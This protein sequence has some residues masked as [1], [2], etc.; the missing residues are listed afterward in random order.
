MLL[1]VFT[2][3]HGYSYWN[4]ENYLLL[5]LT[6]IHWKLDLN[7]CCSTWREN[8]KNFTSKISYE[9]ILETFLSL[10]NKSKEF[11]LSMVTYLLP[12]CQRRK[13]SE[14]RET[15][16]FS[17]SPSLIRFSVALQ[18]HPLRDLVTNCR[19]FWNGLSRNSDFLTPAHTLLP[20]SHVCCLSALESLGPRRRHCVFDLGP[21]RRDITDWLIH[22]KVLLQNLQV[23]PF[24]SFVW[25]FCN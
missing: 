8:V 12:E 13:G 9:A 19:R 11:Q 10:H 7:M 15:S 21:F 2:C 6:L 1:V 16:R 25:S 17:G 24:C 22:S 4:Y 3:F 5:C 20:W 14:V 23:L 18:S